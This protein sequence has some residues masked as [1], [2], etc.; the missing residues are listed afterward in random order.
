[1]IAKS[2][3]LQ[4]FYYIPDR[5][6]CPLKNVQFYRKPVLFEVEDIDS[7]WFGWYL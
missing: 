7:G 5:Q 3:R 6:N 1:M 2:V 4:I